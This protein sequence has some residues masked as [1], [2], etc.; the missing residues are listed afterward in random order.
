MSPEATDMATMLTPF[1]DQ[2]YNRMGLDYQNLRR[3]DNRN[4]IGIMSRSIEEN[5]EQALREKRDEALKKKGRWRSLERRR[6]AGVMQTEVV[7]LQV[8]GNRLGGNWGD[9]GR[10][11]ILSWKLFLFFWLGVGRVF[12]ESV[13]I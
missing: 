10:K 4:D 9:F 12:I 7:L 13:R 3:L 5:D 11:G 2:V 6:A 1:E 8:T